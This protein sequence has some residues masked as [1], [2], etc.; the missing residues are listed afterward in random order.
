MKTLFNCTPSK[1]FFGSQK[2]QPL[3][4]FIILPLQSFCHF[5]FPVQ[6]S[7]HGRICLFSGDLYIELKVIHLTFVFT[8]YILCKQGNDSQ[9][10][11]K[12]LR[13]TLFRSTDELTS[14]RDERLQTESKRDESI[15]R[16]VVVKD[17][18]GGLYAWA[19][20][21]D[22]DFPVYQHTSFDNIQPTF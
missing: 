21:I 9:K 19:K 17:I 15:V 8:V 14:N 16:D 5:E 12:M 1:G 10:A 7:S 11:V 2:P 4:L 3:L 13:E 20:H 6:T 18:A 22:K